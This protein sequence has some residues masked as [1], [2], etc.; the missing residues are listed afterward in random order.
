MEQSKSSDDLQKIARGVISEM[1]KTEWGNPNLKGEQLHY[2]LHE[3]CIQIEKFENLTDL[4]MAYLYRYLM[5]NLLV[6]LNA[7]RRR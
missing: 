7:L 2:K 5:I 6:N 3:K 4:E 1:T